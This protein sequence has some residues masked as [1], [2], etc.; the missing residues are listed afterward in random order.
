[1]EMSTRHEVQPDKAELQVPSNLVDGDVEIR[2]TSGN[3]NNNI[4]RK[5]AHHA[6]EIER[7]QAEAMEEMQSLGE[8]KPK[9]EKSENGAATR[10]V[11]SDLG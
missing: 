1:M 8:G 5:M 3:L 7:Q 6:Q 4:R 11:C 9:K 2:A 10:I